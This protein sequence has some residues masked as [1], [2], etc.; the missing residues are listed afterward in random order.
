MYL[1]VMTCGSAAWHLTVATVLVWPVSV[2]TFAFVLMSH[3][4]KDSQQIKLVQ[5]IKAINPN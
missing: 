1:P 5:L 2:C 4:C 3:T